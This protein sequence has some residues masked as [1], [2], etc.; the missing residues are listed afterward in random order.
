MGAAD[1]RLLVTP[2]RLLTGEEETPH[3]SRRVGGATI[4]DSQMNFLEVASAAPF[5]GFDTVWKRLL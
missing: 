1:Y 4:C 5:F 3:D 2:R